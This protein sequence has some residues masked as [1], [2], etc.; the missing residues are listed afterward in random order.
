MAE[1]VNTLPRTLVLLVT[2][3][4]QP[5][6]AGLADPTRP[7]PG[8]GSDAGGDTAPPALV[9]STVFLMGKRPYAIVDGMTVRVG[10][11]LC[12]ARVTRIDE[13]GVWLAENGGKRLLKLLPDIDKRPPAGKKPMEK[14]R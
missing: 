1:A 2:L 3:A 11:R 8:Q 9:V 12:E 6:W 14:T 4:T 10:D 7:P 13:Q 5:A